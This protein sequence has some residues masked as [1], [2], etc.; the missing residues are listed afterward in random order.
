MTPDELHAFIA[1]LRGL[2]ATLRRA[3][4]DGV[5]S[6]DEL[7]AIGCDVP[8]VVKAVADLARPD[9][10]DHA[11]KVREAKALRKAA[12]KALRVARGKP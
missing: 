5:L 7:V 9:D 1:S 8:A 12:R 10:P 4:A 6:V 2:V 3:L 11:V